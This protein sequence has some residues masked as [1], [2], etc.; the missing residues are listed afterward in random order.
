ML[1]LFCH[2]LIILTLKFTALPV[3]ASWIWG[4]G[5]RRVKCTKLLQ[6]RVVSTRKHLRVGFNL[7]FHAD[8]PVGI[9][10]GQP[11]KNALHSWWF[12]YCCPAIFE[13]PLYLIIDRTSDSCVLSY[14][15]GISL[16]QICRSLPR[17]F[18]INKL[19]LLY[20]L[21]KTV[22]FLLLLCIFPLITIVL[23]ISFTIKRRLFA[24]KE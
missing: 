23:T 19:N 1:Y 17:Y 13:V 22:N 24:R 3:Y 2:N 16:V 15:P 4:W 9:D 21:N 6:N 10:L 5:C 20:Y 14:S 18:C 11:P 8:L 12:F 7:L